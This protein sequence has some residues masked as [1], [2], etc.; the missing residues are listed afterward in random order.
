MSVIATALLEASPP[1]LIDKA[2][3]LLGRVN[4][5]RMLGLLAEG[6]A[7]L[8]GVPTFGFAA[9]AIEAAGDVITG[10]AD[11]EDID[12][13]KDAAKEL[14]DKTKNLLKEAPKREPPEEIAAFRKEFGE[15]L[16]GLD[17]TLVVFIDNLD[18]CL[19]TIL[20]ACE[21]LGLPT[22]R[23][24]IEARRLPPDMQ[25]DIENAVS[26]YRDFKA[27]GRAA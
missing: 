22:D 5:L 1:T 7:A 8:A 25:A 18:R 14:Q 24:F 17:R 20:S 11:K 4:K 10:N 9:R 13:L 3:S 2:K 23:A 15:V 26:A 27:R 16:A 6:G 19:P 21:R 12:A